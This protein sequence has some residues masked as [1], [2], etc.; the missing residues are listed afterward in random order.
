MVDCVIR[1]QW[2]ITHI[3]SFFTPK[4]VYHSG[5]YDP[6][7]AVTPSIDTRH[8]VE[9]AEGA[10]LQLT[11]AGPVVRGIA[12]SIDALIRGV[13]FYAFAMVLLF[14]SISS[15]DSQYVF[16]VL[17]LAYFAISWLYPMLFEAT[18]GTTPGK[19]IFRLIV[20]HDNA[21]PLTVGG[22][23]VRNLLRAVDFLPMMYFIGLTSCVM[24]NRFRR[25]GDLAAGTLVVY[26]DSAD[27]TTSSFTHKQS[28][29]PPNGL[30]REERLAIVDFAERSDSLS[31]ER[32]QELAT[33]LAYLMDDDADPV[34]TLKRWAEWILRGQ[35]NAES[36]SV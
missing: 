13:T 8:T 32:Q 26:R 35:S 1:Q 10:R 24:D 5:E 22:S 27:A 18:T 6:L 4:E 25:L 33:K 36:T 31:D 17:L 3:P 29:A 12:W 11:V 28:T 15:V 34:E 30:L 7:S 20:V 23:V 2:W 9:T 19:R 21:T 14:S 16:G